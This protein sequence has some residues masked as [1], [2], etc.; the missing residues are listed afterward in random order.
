MSDKTVRVVGLLP[1]GQ[2]THIRDGKKTARGLGRALSGFG[3]CPHA[4]SSPIC[5]AENLQH[6]DCY[7][8]VHHRKI[9]IPGLIMVPYAYVGREDAH[10]SQHMK[11][12]HLVLGD[13]R[14]L[15][16]WGQGRP[17]GVG[18]GESLGLGSGDGTHGVGGEEMWGE[19]KG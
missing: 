19:E 7:I 3:R 5:L 1:P 17:H 11:T 16:R 8:P 15:G 14:Y 13:N 4:G 6:S 18:Q 9:G 12:S 10:R 2:H